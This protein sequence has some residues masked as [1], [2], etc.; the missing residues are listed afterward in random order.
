MF[1]NVPDVLVDEPP[2][3]QCGDS[4][5]FQRLGLS[6]GSQ[7][8]VSQDAITLE[9]QFMTEASPP[10]TGYHQMEILTPSPV[11]LQK[12]QDISPVVF[13]SVTPRSTKQTTS[14][15]DDGVSSLSNFMYHD[16]DP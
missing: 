9:N 15:E 6:A 4:A 1:P 16:R 8:L 13:Q 10:E 7:S 2:N 14:G 11:S 3:I 5:T 12:R